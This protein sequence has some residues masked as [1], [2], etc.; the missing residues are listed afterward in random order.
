MVLVSLLARKMGFHV[1]EAEVDHL[2]R[3]GG[4]QSLQG[5]VGKGARKLEVRRAGA[6]DPPGLSR[7]SVR[8]EQSARTET[9]ATRE[10][11]PGRSLPGAGPGTEV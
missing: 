11:Q 4:T 5:L 3:K 8:T 10:W 1:A 6:V 9:V 2:P 7:L